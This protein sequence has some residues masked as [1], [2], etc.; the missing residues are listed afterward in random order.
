MPVRW[1]PAR[2]AG[3]ATG[4][5]DSREWDDAKEAYADRVINILERYAPG[6]RD[7]ILRRF[8]L[9]PADLERWNPNLVGGEGLGGS[10]HLM[11]NFFLRPFPGWSRYRTPIDRL[12]MCGASTWPGAGAGVGAGSRFLLGKE[13]TKRFV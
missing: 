2:I 1:V 13:L 4:K 5:I 12:Y 7:Q 9:S 10:H 11:Q 6:L 3:D 8:V